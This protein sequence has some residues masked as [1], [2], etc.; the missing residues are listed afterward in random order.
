MTKPVASQLGQQIFGL[1][2][3]VA[4]LGALLEARGHTL[5]QCPSSSVGSVSLEHP[6]RGL[7]RRFH[8]EIPPWT[9]P[10]IPGGPCVKPF[11]TNCSGPPEVHK[12]SYRSRLCTAFPLQIPSI[13]R[14]SCSSSR[15]HT[16][17]SR[18][19]QHQHQHPADAAAPA[20]TTMPRND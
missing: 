18:Q 8:A 16:S 17:S 9:L 3:S 13:R 14:H 2:P 20:G 5:M 12:G 1:Q 11:R 15:T 6:E 7:A 4:H 10:H 19:R